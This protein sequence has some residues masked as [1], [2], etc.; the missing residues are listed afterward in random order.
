MSVINE[1]SLE[2]LESLDDE[3]QQL[4][5][6][7]VRIQLSSGIKALDYQKISSSQNHPL[8]SPQQHQFNQL[9]SIDH[10][11]KRLQQRKQMIC[12]ALL[13]YLLAIQGQ[14]R[15]DFAVEYYY[16]GNHNFKEI[17]DHIGL[18]LERTYHLR[19][20]VLERFRNLVSSRMAFSDVAEVDSNQ[21]C[22]DSKKVI[23]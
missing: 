10:R 23:G 13:D 14:S 8:E 3:L 15:R 4:E 18:S 19:R 5:R 17:A 20:E 2:E 21:Q 16:R 7:K 11:I 12:S 9:W 6:L 22:S 1:H